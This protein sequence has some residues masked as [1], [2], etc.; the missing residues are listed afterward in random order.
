MG[1]APRRGPSDLW[2]ICLVVYTPVYFEA[3]RNTMSAADNNYSTV[4]LTPRLTESTH[5]PPKSGSLV[6]VRTFYQNPAEAWLAIQNY[7]V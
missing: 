1:A 5:V 4:M 6:A 3:S 2:Y 7:I